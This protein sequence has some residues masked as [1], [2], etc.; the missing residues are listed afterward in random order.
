MGILNR[1]EISTYLMSAAGHDTAGQWEPCRA[2]T[3]MG[4]KREAVARFGDGFA[5]HRILLAESAGAGPPRVI[6]ERPMRGR[7]SDRNADPGA[8]QRQQRRRERLREDGG[9]WLSIPL[10]ADASAALR[11]LA[12]ATRVT[13]EAAVNAAILAAVQRIE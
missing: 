2:A 8:N 10:T 11:R 1:A 6:A 9:Q 3:L 12:T 4:A 13:Q 5:H 7:W